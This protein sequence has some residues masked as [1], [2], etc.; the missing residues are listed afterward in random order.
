MFV[1]KVEYTR[2]GKVQMLAQIFRSKFSPQVVGEQE[3]D[4]R[5]H[6]GITALLLEGC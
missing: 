2:S 6:P 4:R 3:L 5:T 1:K